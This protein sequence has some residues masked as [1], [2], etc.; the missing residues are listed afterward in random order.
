MRW[1]RAGVIVVTAGLCLAAAR[2]PGGN[3]DADH[4]GVSDAVEQMLLTQFLPRLM[5][6]RRDC[7]RRPA[8]FVAGAAAPRV[9]AADGTLYGQVFPL[10]RPAGAL[11]IHYYD[12]WASD[13]GAEGH[14][15]DA[16]HV[17]ALVEPAPGGGWRAAY[18]YAAAHEDTVCDVS[19]VAPAAALGAA[20]HG[21]T[22]WVSEGKH[23]AFLAPGRCAHGCGNDRCAA[24]VP[25][26]VPRVVNL[27]EVGHPLH[28]T[29]WAA[30]AQWPLAHKMA[31]SDFPPA[32]LAAVPADGIA[33]FHPGRHPLQGVV[34]IS[35][36]TADDTGGALATAQDKTGGSVGSGYR[37]T[38]RAL[39]RSA[40]AVAHFLRLGSGGG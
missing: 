1:V 10:A 4:D 26:T 34:A 19:Q 23:A 28:G 11:E 13:C 16:E 37:Q 2:G 20:E 8:R 38:L 33:L 5:I 24:A 39:R 7:A 22:V 9:A 29:R 14:A 35:S 17:A 36:R 32:A 21:A 30:A 15:L 3:A 27:G 40:A 31:T 25:L 18:W 6:A 12:L